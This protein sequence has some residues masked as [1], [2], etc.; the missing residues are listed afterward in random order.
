LSI[1]DDLDGREKQN[2]RSEECRYDIQLSDSRVGNGG[3]ELILDVG[4]KSEI[5]IDVRGDGGNIL[6]Q[7]CLKFARHVIVEMFE[8]AREGEGA[9]RPERS[10]RATEQS[11]NCRKMGL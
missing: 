8:R 10:E 2:S 6:E 9:G 5:W 11:K 4:G 1:N 3:H 7:L